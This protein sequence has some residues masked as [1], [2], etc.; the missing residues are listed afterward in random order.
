M[1]RIERQLTRLSEQEA[2]LHEAMAE[3]AVDHVAVAELDVRL[4]ALQAERDDL[5]AQWLDAAE[6]AG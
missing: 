6:I 1:A 5:E 3:Q 4:R 2:R